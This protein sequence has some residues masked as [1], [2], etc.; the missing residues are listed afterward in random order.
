LSWE[1]VKRIR[2]ITKMKIVLKGISLE[3]APSRCE[4][5]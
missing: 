2:N 3:D 4:R 1:M 5:H